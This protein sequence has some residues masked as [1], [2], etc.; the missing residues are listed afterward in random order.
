MW[1]T[2]KNLASSKKAMMAF[3]SAVVWGAAKIGFDVPTEHLV[4]VVSPL[5]MFIFAQGVSDHGKEKVLAQAKLGQLGDTAESVES[6]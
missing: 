3:V 5:W 6:P 1:K 2:A 4:G